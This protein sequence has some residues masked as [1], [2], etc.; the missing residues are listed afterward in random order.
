MEYPPYMLVGQ[1]Q[2]RN[3]GK[4]LLNHKTVTTESQSVLRAL[5]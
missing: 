2:G 5:G 3:G 4:E 1:E